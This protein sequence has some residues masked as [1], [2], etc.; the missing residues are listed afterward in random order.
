MTVLF[1]KRRAQDRF[2][3][4]LR[5]YPRATP[6]A[7]FCIA[8]LFV[9]IAARSVELAERRTWQAAQQAV[10]TDIASGLE[11]KAASD[12]AYLVTMASLFANVGAPSPETF[13][14]YISRLRV[15]ENLSGVVG[16]GWIDEVGAGSLPALEAR[17]GTAGF[18]TLQL[19]PEA[20]P[21]RW[22]AYLV[23][24]IEPQ[25]AEN[26]RLLGFN[27][28]NEGRRMVAMDRA[29][30]SGAVTATDNIQ[31]TQDVDQKRS[32]GFLV[33]APVRSVADKNRFL[34]FVYLPV[35]TQDFVKAAVRRNLL[36]NGRIE[37]IDPTPQG[38]ETIFSSGSTTGRFGTV[39]D[40][41][42]EV[43]DQQWILR[44][45][46]P[47]REGFYPLSLVVLFGGSAFSTLLLAY[48]LLVQRRNGDLHAL[49][50]AQLVQEKERAAFIRELNHRVKNTLAN[51][52]SMIALSRY[53]TDNVQVFADTLLQRVKALAA[54]H[55]LL[56]GQQ[57]GPTDLR[58]I[59]AT[60]LS[61][62]DSTGERIEIEGPEVMISPN[63][64]L[65]IGLAIHE[66]ATN[67]SRYGALSNDEGQVK[68]HWREVDENWVEVDWQEAGGPPVMQPERLGLGLNL[69]Q[70]ALAHEL[71]RPIEIDF[72]PE[73]LHCHFCVQRRVP[74]SF[75]LRK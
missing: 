45:A 30:R 57:W 75:Q 20:Q 48:V 43:F 65:T 55:S 52:T 14:A 27:M 15:I 6:I 61:A 31:L 19:K 37:L 66:L 8:L 58:S 56:D 63:D 26:R 47:A 46:P 22:P 42:I 24:M 50:D 38:H 11:R 60:Q 59:I 44:Y 74:R 36:A 9:I 17:I 70:R 21:S 39:P 10:A 53:R 68:V 67:A 32:P 12:S 4:W 18:R 25:T 13:S 2:Q 3:D 29:R 41:K 62:H 71:R 23:T 69:V 49:L 16:V 28:A 73:G 72:N 40:E 33:V 35:R 64:A 5:D 7:V 54:G 51:V 34:G 1:F